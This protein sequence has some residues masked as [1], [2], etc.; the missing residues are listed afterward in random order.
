MK[1]QIVFVNEKAWKSKDISSSDIYLL[2]LIS[3]ILSKC[4]FFLIQNSGGSKIVLR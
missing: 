2:N 4:H 1:R 3:I